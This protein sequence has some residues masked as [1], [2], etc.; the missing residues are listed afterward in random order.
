MESRLYTVIKKDVE[1]RRGLAKNGRVK[2]GDFY[3]MDESG[4]R[5]GAAE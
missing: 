1:S 3:A 5:Q 2:K 4:W